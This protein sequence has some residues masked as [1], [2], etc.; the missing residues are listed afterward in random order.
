MEEKHY[1]K[2]EKYQNQ[3]HSFENLLSE[4]RY[5]RISLK[6]GARIE[7]DPYFWENF[8][9]TE[10]SS[11]NSFVFD[12]SPILLVEYLLKVNAFL[13]RPSEKNLNHHDE[14]EQHS[15]DL[16]TQ[17]YLEIN[18]FVFNAK[19]DQQ[20]DKQHSHENVH[21]HVEPVEG[22]LDGSSQV[23]DFVV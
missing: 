16:K 17:E 8:G 10:V 14:V 9:Q 5:L 21:E 18:P 6:F 20:Q 13:V 12:I 15:G 22:L 19:I 3:L 1:H 23:E 7:K 4:K 2:G 11:H